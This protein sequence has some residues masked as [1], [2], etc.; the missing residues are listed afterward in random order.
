M[1]PIFI[2]DHPKKNMI[3][4]Q[5]RIG[6]YSRGRMFDRNTPIGEAFDLFLDGVVD[7][8]IAL[9]VK[10]NPNITNEQVCDEL[11]RRGVMLPRSIY[12]HSKK[13][14]ATKKGRA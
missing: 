11:D 8:H 5:T 3:S 4:L 12:K 2:K 6:D 10:G 9:I 13:K 1:N 7:E 14:L